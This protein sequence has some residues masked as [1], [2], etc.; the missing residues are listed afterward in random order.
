MQGSLG[1]NT[2]SVSGEVTE[3]LGHQAEAFGLHLVPRRGNLLDMRICRL[4]A[5]PSEGETLGGLGQ[6]SGFYQA[7]LGMLTPP[8]VGDPLM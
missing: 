2:V 6:E 3:C 5:R 1:E 8:P 4:H 7:L